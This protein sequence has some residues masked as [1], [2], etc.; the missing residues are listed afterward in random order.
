MQCS[1]KSVLVTYLSVN[2]TFLSL[3]TARARVRNGHALD[4]SQGHRMYQCRR[5]ALRGSSRICRRDSSRSS[6]VVS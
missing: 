4:S 1:C 3:A 6:R 2:P 5:R